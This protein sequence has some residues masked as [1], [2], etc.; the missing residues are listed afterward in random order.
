M[1][2]RDMMFLVE[3]A[4]RSFCAAPEVLF[5]DVPGTA[6][7]IWALACTIW[8]IR[9]GFSPFDISNSWLCEEYAVLN[10]VYSLG[11]LP[12]SYATTWQKYVDARKR[13]ILKM[14]RHPDR[15]IDVA[16]PNSDPGFTAHKYQFKPG[17]QTL[18]ESEDEETKKLTNEMR[19]KLN[20]ERSYD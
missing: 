17:R 16:D 7:D 8:T 6:S 1:E 4:F 12:D 3:S 13:G 18:S 14:G 2:E 15:I 19:R 20:Y 11:P 9:T 10:M 5:L